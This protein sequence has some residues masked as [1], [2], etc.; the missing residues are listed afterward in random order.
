MKPDV[1][2]KRTNLAAKAVD[3]SDRAGDYN[4][5]GTYQLAEDCSL[6]LACPGCGW[7][8]EMR[9]GLNH[10]PEAMPSW[11]MTQGPEGITLLPSINCKGC[12]GWHG[13]LTKGMFVSC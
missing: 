7:T 11:A 2:P 3:L 6:V 8:S 12:C 1:N 13:Y 4:E 10:K 9:V 5:P